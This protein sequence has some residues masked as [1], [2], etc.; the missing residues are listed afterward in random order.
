MGEQ[1]LA[2]EEGG[3]KGRRRRQQEDAPAAIG[4]PDQEAEARQDA[5]KVHSSDPIQQLIE[6]E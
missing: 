5:E 6:I 1:R 4:Q 3:Q 2:R